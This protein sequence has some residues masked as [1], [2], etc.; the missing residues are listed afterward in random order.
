M[1]SKLIY[2]LAIFFALSACAAGNHTSS[3]ADT[4]PPPKSEALTTMQSL[5]TVSIEELERRTANG[6]TQ[7]QAE[8][9]AR[10]GNGNGVEQDLDKAIA[11]FRDAAAKGEADA[12]FYLGMA[13]LSGM[14]VP[15]NE[16]NA[17]MWLEK[18]AA[19][20]SA[21]GQYWLAVMIKD[22]RGGISPNWEA[23]VPYLWKSAMQGYEDAEFL[24]GYAYQEGLGVEKNPE[25]AAYWYRLTNQRA[26][27]MRA[28]Y[29][30]ALMIKAEEIE[31]QPGDPEQLKP[32]YTQNR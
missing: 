1:I 5:S 18:A 16:A 23:A 6:D 9:G 13:N 12:A 2:V 14:G 22:G 32:G 15:S 24:L 28:N 27:N 11:L 26:Y 7:A 21:Q 3:T 25:A 10:Y 30:L 19:N 29:N 4:A 17:V 20:G 31:W 8:L